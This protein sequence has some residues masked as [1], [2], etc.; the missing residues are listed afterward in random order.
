MRGRVL[1]AC[2]GGLACMRGVPAARH[3][4]TLADADVKPGQQLRLVGVWGRAV[5]DGHHA[6]RAVAF[7]PDSRTAVAAGQEIVV[8]DVATRTPLRRFSGHKYGIESVAVSPDGKT[9]AT[10]GFVDHTIIF[11]DAFTGARR[12]EIVIPKNPSVTQGISGLAFS[13]DGR[14]LLVATHDQ[15]LAVYDVGSGATVWAGSFKLGAAGEVDA[16]FSPDGTLVA[17]ASGYDGIAVWDAAT[18]QQLW[19]ADQKASGVAFQGATLAAA[20]ADFG[21]QLIIYDARTGAV[22]TERRKEGMDVA[23]VAAVPGRPGT[24]VVAEHGSAVTIWDEHGTTSMFAHLDGLAGVAVSPDGRTAVSVALDEGVRAWDLDRRREVPLDSHDGAV[25]ALAPSAD[26]ARLA[27]IGADGSVFVRAVADGAIL[28]R[29]EGMH[30]PVTT[31]AFSANGEVGVIASVVPELWPQESNGVYVVDGRT[32]KLRGEL[33]FRFLP[34]SAVALSADGRSAVAV[35]SDYCSRYD[36]TRLTTTQALAPLSE[37]ELHDLK[38]GIQG[39]APLPG[40]DVAVV[41]GT[42]WR[43]WHDGDVL[44]NGVIGRMRM[45]EGKA[46]WMV[47]GGIMTRLATAPDGSAALAG[48]RDGRVTLVDLRSGK[49]RWAPSLQWK[50]SSSDGDGAVIAVALSPDGRFAAAASA[51]GQLRVWNADSGLL[52]DTLSLPSATALAFAPDSRA[53][54]AGSAYGTIFRFA[55]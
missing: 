51:G 52:H 14:R 7:M 11:W 36:L 21:P 44:V 35:S 19:R 39:V 30:A 8:F 6:S 15:R 13:P 32:G 31:A 18:G 12:R 38:A 27:S 16:A 33:A 43:T 4:P 23:R 5:W 50:V 10:G 29:R 49:L 37:D 2:V 22:K 25:M 26:G 46:S 53:L 9:I 17:G 55:L 42:A 47:D 40:G 34:A 24:F 54:Y 28:S 41:T 48:D 1:A 45:P 20:G 3:L